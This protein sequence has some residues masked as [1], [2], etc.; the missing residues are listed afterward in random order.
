MR[1]KVTFYVLSELSEKVGVAVSEE[2][3]LYAFGVNP[4]RFPKAR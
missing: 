4:K 2:W 1:H 3:I